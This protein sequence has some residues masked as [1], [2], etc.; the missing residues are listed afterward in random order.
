MAQ[1]RKRSPHQLPW[2]HRYAAI[3]KCVRMEGTATE[4]EVANATEIKANAD[5][6]RVLNTLRTGML[7]KYEY[8]DA[9]NPIIRYLNFRPPADGGENE[10]RHHLEGLVSAHSKEEVRR[11]TS[12]LADRYMRIKNVQ[13][14][15]LIFLVSSLKL[16]EM[17]AAERC[18]F[19]FKCDFEDISQLA[20]GRVFRKILDA[21]EEEA[22]KGAQFPYFDGRRFHGDMTRVFDSL[23]QTNYWL[24]FLELGEP[25]PQYPTVQSATLAELQRIHPALVEKYH[26]SLASVDAGRALGG[27]DRPIEPVDLLPASEL[28]EIIS[29]MPDNL[30]NRRISLALDQVSVTVPLKEYGSTWMIAE[31]DGTRYIVIKGSLLEVRSKALTPFDVSALPELSDVVAEL[32]L[33]RG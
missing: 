31:Q 16:E 3:F 1:R 33:P 20:P 8:P 25:A 4:I 11:R 2:E 26:D 7:A 28:K 32:K 14:G 30:S 21:F 22:K 9:V 18:V 6:E 29:A 24:E 5:L 19:V 23:G 15:V 10:A 13:S 17:P 12:A 27:D